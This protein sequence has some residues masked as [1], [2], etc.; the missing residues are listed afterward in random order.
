VINFN[1][2]PVG[3]LL[4]NDY[5]ENGYKMEVI[6]GHYDIQG[7]PFS[8]NGTNFLGLDQLSEPSEVLFTNVQGEHFDFIS[9]ENINLFSLRIQSSSGGDISLGNVGV[10]TFTGSNWNNL[11]WL[12][13]TSNEG[14][15]G[16]G[17]DTITLKTVPV[18]TAIW[19]FG[20]G[21]IGLFGL[22]E[23]KKKKNENIKV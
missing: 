3:F 13:F 10:N 23:N 7:L 9:Y 11:S 16:V 17:V 20:S 18:P 22:S 4:T 1:T 2:A 12:S 8:S 19:L 6:S 14:I 5:F 15:G 21:L